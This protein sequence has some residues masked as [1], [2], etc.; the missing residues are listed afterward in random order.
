MGLSM[1]CL[2]CYAQWSGLTVGASRRI[3]TIA[4]R[5]YVLAA[6]LPAGMFLLSFV[7]ISGCLALSGVMFAIFLFPRA[8]VNR[9]AEASNQSS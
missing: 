3:L 8:L 2:W 4:T 6:V 9:L 7:T 5:L 1:S